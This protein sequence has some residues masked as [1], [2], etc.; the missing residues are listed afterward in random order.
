VGKQSRDEFG[1]VDAAKKDFRQERKILSH[2]ADQPGIIQFLGDYQIDY[3]ADEIKDR[4]SIRDDSNNLAYYNIVMEFAFLD[5]DEFFATVKREELRRKGNYI[6]YWDRIFK[7]A[8]ALE[9]LHKMPLP[10][11][12]PSFVCHHFDIKPANIVYVNGEFKFIDFS[13][14]EVISSSAGY[15]Q[16]ISPRG[17]TATYGKNYTPNTILS[18]GFQRKLISFQVL[19]NQKLELN[20][21]L[22]LIFGHME[23]FFWYM[24][25]GWSTV[26]RGFWISQH[27][28][29]R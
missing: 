28:D 26:G 25:L 13:F 17:S 6:E 5:L 29:T 2:L 7:L 24:L 22:R 11:E 3:Q 23:Q 20:F 4:N 16:P 10:E 14:A 27:F 21:H 12:L 1:E 15:D 9:R 19:R 8:P 18:T